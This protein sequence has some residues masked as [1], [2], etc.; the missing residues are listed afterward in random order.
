M[1]FQDTQGLTVLLVSLSL[2]GAK[3]Q[4]AR[5]TTLQGNHTWETFF[6]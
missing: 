4:G 5:A 6:E 1:G 3:Q 2:P